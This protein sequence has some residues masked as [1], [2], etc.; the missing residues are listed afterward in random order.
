MPIEFHCT[1]CNRLLRT[2]DGT[3]GKEARCPA[4][5]TVVRIPTGTE[6]PFARPAEPPGAA[7]NP[8]Q[9]PSVEAILSEDA[10]IPGEFRPTRITVEDVLARTWQIFKAQALVCIAIVIGFQLAIGLMM[11]PIMVVF[12]GVAAALDG[13]Q[14]QGV[15]VLAI[16]VFAGLFIVVWFAFMWLMLGMQRMIPEVARGQSVRVSDMWSTGYAVLPAIGATI[17]TQIA[18][19]GGLLLCIV[20]GIIIGIMLSQSILL[21]IDRRV[22]VIDSLKLSMQATH[23]NKVTLLVLWLLMMLIMSLVNLFTCGL[24]TIVVMPFQM[25]LLCVAY[26]MMTGQVTAPGTGQAQVSP[27]L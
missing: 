14:R 7:V 8:Y 13:G 9:A 16:A 19:L 20:P 15:P 27:S 1:R 2:E 11:V 4:C 3:E 10:A 5:G 17:L 26:L 21:I 23:G 12:F 22:G 25:L 18:V 24:G 6:R